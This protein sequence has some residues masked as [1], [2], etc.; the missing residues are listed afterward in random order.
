[1]EDEKLEIPNDEPLEI[2][3]LKINGEVS[4]PDD[5]S[6]LL[7]ILEKF[8][9]IEVNPDY[10]TNKQVLI[11]QFEKYFGPVEDVIKVLEN[12]E[13]YRFYEEED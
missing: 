13:N 10:G 9:S 6:N 8:G 1:M 3:I 12:T 7:G 11:C 2:R 5:S 4:I